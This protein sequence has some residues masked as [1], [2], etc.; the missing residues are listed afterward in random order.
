MDLLR[1]NLPREIRIFPETATFG[2]STSHGLPHHGKPT[3]GTT[4]GFSEM[5]L[6]LTEF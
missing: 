5:P 2:R 1:K 6:A 3:M 4:T